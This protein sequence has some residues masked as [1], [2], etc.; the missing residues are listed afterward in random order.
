MQKYLVIL[1][2]FFAYCFGGEIFAENLFCAKMG[3][4]TDTIPTTKDTIKATSLDE[5]V[6]KGERMWVENDK[7]V[8]LPTRREKN[9]SNSPASLV[10]AMHLPFLK[11]KEGNIVD[12]A[13][14]TVTVFVNGVK[15]D[16]VDMSTFWPKQV[17]R[18]EYLENPK[19]A[20]YEGVKSAVNFVV[21]EYEVGGVTKFDAFQRMPNYG[22]YN[23][24]SKLVYKKMTFG[25]LLGWRYHHRHGM[26]AEGTETYHDT[27]YNDILYPE[28][29]RTFK[30]NN[31]ERDD[32]LSFALNA[33]YKS[34][35]FRATHNFSFFGSKNPG[36]GGNSTDTWTDN[37]FS[38][39]SSSYYTEGRNNTSQLTGDYWFS[40][41]K[42][43][44]IKAQWKYSFSRGKNDS[45]NRYQEEEK[46]VNNTH[47]DVH[48]A[49]F[50]FVPQFIASK[51]VT[52]QW[53]T[54]ADLDWFTSKYTGSTTAEQKQ[55]R[56]N[57]K[58]AFTMW[59]NPTPSI[60]IMPEV[61]VYATL[62]NIDG[63]RDNLVKPTFK[64]GL[65][66][67]ASKKLKFVGK[68]SLY[69]ES[70]DASTSNPILLKSSELLWIKGNPTLKPLLSWDSQFYTTYFAASWLDLV[71]F[72]NY[73]RT[74]NG[75]VS[76]YEAADASRGGVIKNTLNAEPEDFL[77]TSLDIDMRFFD[78]DL[79][80]TLTPN[81]LYERE[82]GLYAAHFNNFYFSGNVEYSFKKCSLSLDYES[83]YKDLGRAGVERSW[84]NDKWCASFTYGNGNWFLLVKVDDIFNK[85]ARSW[86]KFN[87][88]AFTSYIYNKKWGRSISIS[89]TYTFGYGKRVD[90]SID[91]N[92]SSGSKTSIV[93]A[94]TS[95]DR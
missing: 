94:G 43:W 42:D 65:S 46:I 6:V 95:G 77:N 18:V 24:S 62:W 50:M 19:D 72:A 59:W 21:P 40:L 11:E 93:G 7:I 91:V 23:G 63:E 55:K 26:S 82:R 68:V 89:L 41:P 67:K 87:E 73:V 69:T 39:T 1:F 8:A 92:A 78:D 83:P 31:Y 30:Q 16:N 64:L 53:R 88:N 66:A 49:S 2:F 29:N 70:P 54:T 15:A 57:I 85:K 12:P 10:G 81:W 84:R 61:G 25:I 45:W 3:N 90:H 56:Q 34:K 20:T 51:K 80:V 33:K 71:F 79:T 52:F 48:S 13:G 14:E 76:I 38:S 60:T 44:Y 86:S 4:I 36:S 75:F 35:N 37:L 32:A 47:E 9:L 17:R 28:I 22:S 74:K 27:Y 5:A 58:S